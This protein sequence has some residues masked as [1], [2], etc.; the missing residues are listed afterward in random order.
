[1]F[2]FVHQGGARHPFDPRQV[3]SVGGLL[4]LYD[5]GLQVGAVDGHVGQVEA[6]ALDLQAFELRPDHLQAVGNVFL[7]NVLQC[8]VFQALPSRKDLRK[9]RGNR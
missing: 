3:D 9:E 4:F 5:E 2:E 1:M 6:R 8:Q 7:D